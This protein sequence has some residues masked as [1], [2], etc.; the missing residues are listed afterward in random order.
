MVNYLC[1]YCNIKFCR[2]LEKNDWKCPEKFKE[3]LVEL[4][5]NAKDYFCNISSI[6]KHLEISHDELTTQTHK[7]FNYNPKTML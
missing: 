2:N 3:F 5:F 4:Q 1:K 6:L 7:Y